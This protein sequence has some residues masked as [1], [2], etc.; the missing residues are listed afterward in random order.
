MNNY[1]LLVRVMKVGDSDVSFNKDLSNTNSEGFKKLAKA[2]SDEVNKA[3]SL[4]VPEIRS[5]YLGVDVTSI[6][7]TYDEDDGVLVNLTLK[8]MSDDKL[9]EDFLREELV[10][11]LEESSE[12]GESLPRPNAL[13]TAEVEDVMDFDECSD[14]NYNDC[15]SAA[16][17]INEPGSYTC[18][19]KGVFTDLSPDPSLPGRSCAAELKSCDLCNGRGDCYRD[20]MGD[21][22]TCKCQRMFLGRFCEINGMRELLHPSITNNTQSNR[23]SQDPSCIHP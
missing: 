19:C 15:H 1:V 8:L 7:R 20:E 12:G 17:C 22:T 5:N 11:T 9:N 13:I 23:F 6:G 16:R 21:V 4:T 10:K 3:Y 18:K 14:P 2:T